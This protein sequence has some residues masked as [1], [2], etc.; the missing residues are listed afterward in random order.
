MLEKELK[1]VQLDPT[2][3]LLRILEDVHTDKT[4]TLIERNGE[5]LAVIVDP[6]EYRIATAGPK[7]KRL[8]NE[9]LSLAGIWS[10]LDADQ[11][12]EELYS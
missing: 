10:D 7:S 8:R 6:E 2:T 3:N 12:I 4:P 11:M 9:L 5:A 1:R